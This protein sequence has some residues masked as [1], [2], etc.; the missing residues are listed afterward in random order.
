MLTLTATPHVRVKALYCCV[1][2]VLR[3]LAFRRTF[4]CISRRT[5]TTLVSLISYSYASNFSSETNWSSL[6]ILQSATCFYRILEFEF[7][8]LGF[9]YPL[10]VELMKCGYCDDGFGIDHHKIFQRGYTSRS[11]LSILNFMTNAVV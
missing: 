3:R 5:T 4:A 8:I 9:S 7:E 6:D 1:P 11:S 2:L 10:Y